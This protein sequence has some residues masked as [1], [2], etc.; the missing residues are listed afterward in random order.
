M[1]G[2]SRGSRAAAA[3]TPPE[4]GLR[5]AYH[6]GPPAIHFAGLPWTRGIAQDVTAA[7]WAEMRARGDFNEF[8][9]RPEHPAESED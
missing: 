5:V 1:R 6:G 8:D 3:T 7:K 9:F 2:A 4:T